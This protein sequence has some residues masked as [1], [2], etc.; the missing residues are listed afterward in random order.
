MDRKPSAVIPLEI[1]SAEESCLNQAS[2][3]SHT[4]WLIDEGTGQ[5]QPNL[6]QLWPAIPIPSLPKR[7]AEAATWPVVPQFL[8][9]T[10][11][12]HFDSLSQCSS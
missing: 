3:V 2:L 9:L 8:P 7:W 6:G 4:Q 10:T 11:A 12:V 5:F 1:V